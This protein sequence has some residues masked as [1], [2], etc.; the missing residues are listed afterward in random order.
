MVGANWRGEPLERVSQ[1]RL[2]GWFRFVGRLQREFNGGFWNFASAANEPG[3]GR[4]LG[5]AIQRPVAAGAE[6][7]WHT[8][9]IIPNDEVF[10]S[11][12]EPGGVPDALDGQWGLHNEGQ[13]QL[14]RRYDFTTD[15]GAFEPAYDESVYPP[16]PL[17]GTNDSDI[18]APEAWQTTTGSLKS[19]VGVIDTG[20]DYTHPDLYRNIWV[21][22]GEI[23]AAVK[24]QLV[25]SNGDGLYTFIDFNA[26]ANAGITVGGRLAFNDVNNNGYI[27]GWDLLNE[28][29][30]LDFDSGVNDVWEVGGDG[31]GNGYTD[32][33]IG[34]N[35][36]GN[37]NDP[38]DTHFHGTHVAGTIGA[39]GNND[40]GVAGVNWNVS[41]I[42]LRVGIPLAP[43]YASTQALVISAAAAAAVE[44]TN[45]LRASQGYHVV[46]TNNSYGG[47]V[48]S[49]NLE[50]AILCA[51]AADILFVAAAG[52]S[53]TNIDTSPAYP[54]SFDIDNIISVG[55]SDSSDNLAGFSNYG[56]SRV[57]LAA[58]G[59]NILSTFPSHE[60]SAMNYFPRNSEWTYF[61]PEYAVISGT[62]M[63]TPHVVGVAALLAAKNSTAGAAQIKQAILSSAEVDSASSVYGKVLT[64]GRLNA[65]SC[66]PRCLTATH[67]SFQFRR[68]RTTGI[69]Q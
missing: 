58:P 48:K 63:A 16:I 30:N 20:V 3:F 24:S 49:Y 27:D 22:Q 14:R 38:M 44:Y 66:W 61:G 6:F 28:Q 69:M 67:L 41:M 64:N 37:N 13:Q 56:S 34:W 43:P 55:A 47:G 26:P 54:A 29:I 32:D 18:D 42:P 23:P 11:E 15:T 31:D 45:Q 10:D 9:A 25:D 53:A 60:T 21:N 46:A 52:N 8:S 36:I 50:Q 51:A 2:V 59:L 62:S 65:A 40:L 33:L 57:D 17:A 7:R 5:G 19:V 68:T 4:G 39:M 12:F 1:R 35:F